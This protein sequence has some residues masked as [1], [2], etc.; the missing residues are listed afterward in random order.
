[1]TQ[2]ATDFNPT[3]SKLL[4]SVF[5]VK[6]RSGSLP[7]AICS[8]KEGRQA[9]HE[10]GDG[11]N[12]KHMCSCAVTVNMQTRQSSAIERSSTA[13]SGLNVVISS[14]QSLNKLEFTCNSRV[15]HLCSARRTLLPF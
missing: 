5:E 10:Q 1:M 14:N 9:G 7:E 6:M 8:F 2:R 4:C 12:V 15:T 3:F 13:S 11:S